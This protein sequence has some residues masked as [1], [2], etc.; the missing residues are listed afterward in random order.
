MT[1]PEPG[2]RPRYQGPGWSVDRTSPAGPCYSRH[3]PGK[4]ML[5]VDAQ[6]PHRG[7]AWHLST[8]PAGSLALPA[9]AL[10]VP[11]DG[12]AY[13]GAAMRD[14]DQQVALLPP[15]MFELLTAGEARELYRRLARAGNWPGDGH[16]D[17][18]E[19]F[20]ELCI[21]IRIHATEHGYHGP[22]PREFTQAVREAS[23]GAAEQAMNVSTN[24][25]SRLAMPGLLLGLATPVAIAAMDFPAQPAASGAV[26]HGPAAAR[27]GPARPV[28]RVTRGR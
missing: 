17:L 19:V 5:R 27:A 4:G 12:F 25:G 10:T 6:G 9:D 20:H 11:Q 28:P 24:G 22:D 7:Y 1:V 23:Y 26:R 16:T 13:A 8:S 3:V 2:A 21:Q 14:A 15:R 18:D